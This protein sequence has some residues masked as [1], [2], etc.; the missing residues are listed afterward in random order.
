M[1]KN[2]SQKR[3]FKWPTNSSIILQFLK[4][5]PKTK[6]KQDTEKWRP[7]LIGKQGVCRGESTVCRDLRLREPG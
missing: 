1:D 6:D 2:K 3:L 7:L 4:D 5:K